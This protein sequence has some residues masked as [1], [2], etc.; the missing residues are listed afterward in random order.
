MK[1]GGVAPGLKCD[2]LE[3]HMNLQHMDYVRLGKLTEYMY[4]Q[5][6]SGHYVLKTVPQLKKLLNDYKDKGLIA[7]ELVKD[8]IKQ[9]MKW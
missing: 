8:K 7:Q 6:D 2:L 4:Q 5:L 9:A 3:R 1:R